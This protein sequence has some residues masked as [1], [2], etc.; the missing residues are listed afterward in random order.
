[1]Y[2]DMLSVGYL[3]ERI[4]KSVSAGIYNDG[5][6]VAW[7]LTHDDG[8]LGSMHVLKNTGERDTQGKFPFH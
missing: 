7:A 5:K 8:S 4:E 2:K 1:M 3:N 6:L